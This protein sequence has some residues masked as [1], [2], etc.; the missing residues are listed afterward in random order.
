METPWTCRDCGGE[1]WVD[2]ESLDKWPL[3]RLMSAMGYVCKHCGMREAISYT[4]P[5]MRAAERK[6]TRYAPGHRKFQ[7]V[8]ASLIRKQSG[9]NAR[10]ESLYGSSR[11]PNVA[12]P[13]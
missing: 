3:D 13:G 9:V 2:L 8:L 6:L 7:F 12:V 10:G 5:S 4:T 11:H 1:N